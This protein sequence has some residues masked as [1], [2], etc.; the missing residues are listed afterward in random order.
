MLFVRY[1]AK[2]WRCSR[3]REIGDHLV[4]ILQHSRLF[5]VH[6]AA[7]SDEKLVEEYR[8]VEK[9]I[10]G[11][12]LIN[13]ASGMNSEHF[14]GF[15]SVGFGGNNGCVYK[16]TRAYFKTWNSDLKR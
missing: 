7:G 8:Y 11:A 2:V 10:F 14:A 5:F 3:A 12:A 1:R 9:S 6:T 4:Q 13:P 15:C 16:M